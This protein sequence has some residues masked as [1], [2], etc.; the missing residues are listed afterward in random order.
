VVTQ[1]APDDTNPALYPGW[2]GIYNWGAAAHTATAKNLAIKGLYEYIDPNGAEAAALEADGY[3]RVNWGI[4]IWSNPN[5]K[6][7][8]NAAILDGVAGRENL[9]PRYFHPMPLTV[10]DQSKG[11][12][13]NG[14]GLPNN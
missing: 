6:A 5:A 4:T 13:T 2:R 1:E 8:F 12:V 3:I 14:Y 11:N 7:M 9:A 10:I